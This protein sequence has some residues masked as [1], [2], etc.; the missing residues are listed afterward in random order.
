MKSQIVK[1]LF[2]LFMAFVCSPLTSSAKAVSFDPALSSAVLTQTRMLEQIFKK[3]K[4]T[5][6]KIIA[7]DVAVS[8]TLTR[9][10]NV[11]DCILKYMSNVSGALQNLYEIKRAAKLVAVDIP[12]KMA[13]VRRAVGQGHFEGTFVGTLATR[14][15]V[16]IT[17]DMMTLYPFMRELVVSGSYSFDEYDAQLQKVVT[18]HKKVNLLNSAE[19]Y[20]V[21]NTVLNKLEDIDNQLE[22]LAWNI[23][24]MRW[25]DFL[26][27]LDPFGWNKIMGGYFIADDV[28]REW[29]YQLRHF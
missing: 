25:R 2:L 7:A 14:R 29:K 12:N 15:L 1:G 19:R 23:R 6:D 3:R 17:E 28:V 27:S 18:R 24:T 13:L 26:Y 4:K 5:Q 9:M 8:A 16:N 20:Y 10:H 22:Y 21:C 11:E